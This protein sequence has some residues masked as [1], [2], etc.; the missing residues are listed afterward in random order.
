MP[1]LQISTRWHLAGKAFGGVERLSVLAIIAATLCGGTVAEAVD[2]APGADTAAPAPPSAP[3]DTAPAFKPEDIS[4]GEPISLPFATPLAPPAP[5]RPPGSGRFPIPTAAAPSD[6]AAPTPAA[7]LPSVV[8]PATPAAALQPQALSQAPAYTGA[9]LDSAAAG[10][11]WL[12]IAVD[13]AVVT[14]RLVVVEVAPDGP[15]AKAGVRPQDMLL[16]INGNHLQNGDELAA[17]LAAIV[18]GQRVK[19]A[20]GRDNR[21]EDVVA[22]ASPRPPAALSRNWQSAATS[23]NPPPNASVAISPAAPPDLVAPT[24]LVPEA[25]SLGVL[26]APAA[27]AS[28]PTPPAML[29]AAVLPE[30]APANAAQVSSSQGV[31]PAP[32]GRTALGV[33]TVPV[34]PNVQTRFRLSD[35][36]GAFVIGV[37]QDLPASKAGVPPGSVIVAINHQPVRSPQDLTHLVARGPVGTPVPLQYVLPGG[38]SKQADVVLQSLEQPLERALIGSGDTNQTTEQP[39][40]Q[41]APFQ[42]GPLTTRRVQPTAGYQSAEQSNETTGLVRLEELLRRMNNRLEQIER[43]LERIESGR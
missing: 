1:L 15:A 13:D 8:A 14:G 28:T 34:D 32:G 33:R 37:V 19:M 31:N 18:P 16:A 25:P 5:E 2:S 39:L 21:V 17:A 41:P 7:Q 35:A 38:Q 40:L 9:S 27:V 43:R 10:T 30:R 6:M 12:G 20:V 29:S 42:P 4:I 24:R 36:Q 22:Q 23:H 26:P 11:G 3:L